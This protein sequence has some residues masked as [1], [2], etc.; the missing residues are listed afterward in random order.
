MVE[1]V[2]QVRQIGQVGTAARLVGG[3]AAIVLPVVVSGITW[4]DVG[5]ALVALPVI[6]A[7][8]AAAASSAYRRHTADRPRPNEAESWIRSTVALALVLGVGIPLTF[9]SAVD[10]TAIW[11]FLGLSILLAA[12]RGDAGCEVTAI[13]NAL[14]GRKDSTGCVIYAP[15]DAAEARR[16][17]R[18]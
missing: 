13:P 3:L 6:A 2:N 5:A 17:K 8:A 4:W 1:A 10:G 18:Y 16:A 15:I 9:V 7:L 11:I 14:V 12:G